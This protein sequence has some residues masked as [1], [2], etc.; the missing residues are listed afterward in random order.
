LVAYEGKLI[1]ISATQV[2]SVFFT[3]PKNVHPV[4][5]TDPISRVLA[6]SL[7]S[8]DDGRVFSVLS[9]AAIFELSELPAIKDPEP[10]RQM[11]DTDLHTD[12]TTENELALP[13]LLMQSNGF[14]F[15]IHPRDIETTITNLTLKPGQLEGDYYMGDIV[16][17]GHTIP[18][19]NLASYLGLGR[20]AKAAFSQ[21]FV[22]RLQQGPVA[23]LLDR[24]V[25][26]VRVE[27]T[28]VVELPS[29]GF[30]KPDAFRGMVSAKSAH[31][32]R[33]AKEHDQQYF[34][35]SPQGFH[36]DQSLQELANV[37]S[38]TNIETSNQQQTRIN[39]QA[40]LNNLLIFRLEQELCTPLE[41][42]TEVLPYNRNL[43]IFERGNP[44]L[45]ILNHRSKAIPVFD[46]SQ[47]LGESRQNLSDESSVLLIEQDG[48]LVG[49]AVQS[50]C[51]I[52]SA[53]WA[54]DVPVLGEQRQVVHG[55]LKEHRRLAEVGT[56]PQRRM[57]ELINLKQQ[58]LE[59]C[60]RQDLVAAHA[61]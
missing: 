19:V 12:E 60:A 35:L 43:E 17:R 13:L 42:V 44:M 47:W 14:L 40:G 51:S 15:A 52:E 11:L 8:P 16:Y 1:G 24:V 57:I 21:A 7:K 25:D 6:G 10:H 55:T 27:H 28:D 2:Q 33:P 37:I 39:Q 56:G 49:F 31:P 41:D 59:T 5:S 54:P 23:F 46:L 36:A 58:V 20:P 9:M 3:D 50:L 30:K 29:V 53:H 45:G 61:L 48:N 18:A 26:I 32:P 22:V 38:Q 4:Q 34:V